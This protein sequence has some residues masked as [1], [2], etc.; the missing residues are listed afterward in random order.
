MKSIS[1]DET[2]EIEIST[3]PMPNDTTLGGLMSSTA[4]IVV[5]WV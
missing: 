3:Q 5:V 1:F 4:K 2:L